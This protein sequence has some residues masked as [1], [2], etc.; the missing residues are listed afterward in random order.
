[1][2][3][4]IA[5]TSQ[6]GHA[7]PSA[8]GELP[9]AGHSDAASLRNGSAK[10]HAHSGVSKCFEHV[11][12]NGRKDIDVLGSGANGVVVALTV[13]NDGDVLK[14][15]T[16]GCRTRLTRA[17]VVAVGNG[18]QERMTTNGLIVGCDGGQS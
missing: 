6:N 16:A 13:V 3:G 10:C 2:L 15:N 1:M 4:D 18:R 17:A 7:R 9:S 14:V 11:G 8:V 12:G 5:L